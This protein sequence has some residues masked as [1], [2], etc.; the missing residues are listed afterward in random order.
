MPPRR[1]RRV[2]FNRGRLLDALRASRLSQKEVARRTK[3][4]QQRI[5]YLFKKA[6]TID[7]RVLRSVTRVLNVPAGYLRDLRDDFPRARQGQPRAARRFIDECYRKYLRDMR[8]ID[9]KWG[10][11]TK[12][13]NVD[14]VVAVD[15]LVQPR[16]W[17]RVFLRPRRA[18]R[19]DATDYWHL[20]RGDDP[21]LPTPWEMDQ[22]AMEALI[23]AFDLVFKPWFD[24]LAHLDHERVI[25]MGFE[26]F[27]AGQ[28]SQT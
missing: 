13:S 23:H 25:A 6:R 24:G 17:W 2:S 22:L 7:V 12:I 8:R 26:M 19:E 28:D 15:S 10:T 3:F 18:D 1:S 14:F 9:E 27:Q 11:G 16:N 21:D 5:N 20:L 4:S